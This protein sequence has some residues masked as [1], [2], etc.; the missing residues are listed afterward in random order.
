[1]SED[2]DELVVLSPPPVRGAYLSSPPDWFFTTEPMPSTMT[3]LSPAAQAIDKAAENVFF[4]C[5][6]SMIAAGFRALVESQSDYIGDRLCVPVYNIL[7]IANELDPQ[8]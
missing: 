6:R 1:M 2:W 3:E 4:R 8:P 7:E 5:R